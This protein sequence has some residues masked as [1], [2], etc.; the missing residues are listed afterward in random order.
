LYLKYSTLLSKGSGTFSLQS[1]IRQSVP[2]PRVALLPSRDLDPIDDRYRGA[3]GSCLG[4]ATSG[5][6]TGCRH[7][8]RNR[9]IDFGD[10]NH[11]RASGF[12]VWFAALSGSSTEDARST[13][14]GG[15]EPRPASLTPL[16]LRTWHWN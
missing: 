6:C 5:K 11:V 3:V 4:A 15:R 9:P 16:T 10:T 14:V 13:K 8:L 1:A 2:Y 12:A 7:N